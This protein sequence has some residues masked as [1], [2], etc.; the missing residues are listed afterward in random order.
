MKRTIVIFSVLGLLS[1]PVLAE[2]TDQR[3]MDSRKV[4]KEFMGQL[5]GELETAMKAGGPTNAIKVC[6]N[7]APEIAGNMSKKYDWRV[8]RTSLKYRNSNNKPDAWET[9]VLND[10]EARKAKGEDVK[11]ME[12]HEVVTVNGKKEFRYMKAIPTAKVC[13][14]CHGAKINPD[15]KASLKQMYPNDKARGFK[16]GDIRGAFTITQPM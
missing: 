4:V 15:V 8:A 13:V 7:S 3:V 10:F 14:Q 11:K 5:K 1:G 9:K 16:E 12:A 6:K 2:G